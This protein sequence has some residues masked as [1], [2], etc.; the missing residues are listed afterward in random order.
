MTRS[1]HTWFLSESASWP[2]RQCWAWCLQTWWI[3]R[4]VGPQMTLPSVSAPFFVP[5]LPLDR[6]ISGLKNFE[7]G[8]WPLPLTRRW[9]PQVLSPPSLRIMAKVNPVWSWESHISLMSGT[10]LWL[11]PQFLISK[12]VPLS[13]VLQFLILPPLFPPS[14]FSFPCLPLLPPPTYICS[15]GWHC[16]TVMGGEALG[17]GK[18][19]CPRVRGWWSSRAGECGWVREHFHTGKGEGVGQIWDGGLVEGITEK[20]DIIW[21]VNKWN[22]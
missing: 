10:L 1:C 2:Q 14:L 20:W 11:S 15:K 19:W 3:S 18:D 17:P 4:W 22:D 21:D 12:T 16:P 8:G 5:V 9:S 6:N 13:H 7:V